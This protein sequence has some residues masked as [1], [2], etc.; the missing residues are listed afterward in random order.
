M[1]Y[2]T[3]IAYFYGKIKQNKWGYMVLCWLAG[4]VGYV[5]VGMLFTYGIL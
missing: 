5:T 1:K 3:Q 2:L 4:M